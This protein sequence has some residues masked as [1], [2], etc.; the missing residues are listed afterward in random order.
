MTEQR[1]RRTDELITLRRTSLQVVLL[2]LTAVLYV[3]IV[4][5]FARHNHFSEWGWGPLLL[6]V[7]LLVAFLLRWRRPS[8]A[9]LAVTLGLASALFHNAWRGDTR[10][11]PHLLALTSILTGLF[12][13]PVT[14]LGVTGACSGLLIAVGR[15]AWGI[16]PFSPDLWSPILLIGAT[17]V[18]SV[19]TVG[20][21]SQALAWF[22]ERAAAAQANE[23]AAR[24]RQGQLARTLKALDEAYRRLEFANYDLARAR[25]VAE[26]ARV[27]KQEFA[28]RV[29][30]ELRTP[31]N[32]IV[33]L[34][35]IMYHSPERYYD[36]LPS[37]RFR[38]DTHELYRSSR[39]LLHL[40]DDVLDLTRV[41]VREMRMKL[42]PTDLKSVVVESIDMIRPL[43]A[44]DRVALGVDV[45]EHLP[46]VMIDR[47][48]VQQVLLNLLNNARRFTDEGRIWVRA[49]VDEDVVRVT[50]DD[51][52]IGIAPEEQPNVFKEFHQVESALARRHGGSGLGLAISRRFIDLHNGRIWVESSGVP[53]EGSRFH[54]T[55]PIAGTQLTPRGRLTSGRLPVGEPPQGRGRTLLLWDQ[56]QRVQE[57]LE[58]HLETYNVVP[59][60]DAET[61]AR[62]I[63]ERPVQA[64]VINP[65][66]GAQARAEVQALASR[67]GHDRL[68][69]LLCSLVGERELGQR[70]E[71][72]AYLVKPV[73][74]EALLTAV[75]RARENGRPPA[76][77]PRVLIVDN[78]VQMV[79]LL[80][81]MLQM[82]EVTETIDRA[83]GG[84]QGLEMMR[85]RRPDLVL[86][87]LMMPGVDG[88]RV[89]TEMR[90]DPELQDV[91]VIVITAQMHSLEHERQL[92]SDSLV[93]R[94]P[95][96]LTN[97]EV[98][99]Y[100]GALLQAIPVTAETPVGE[101]D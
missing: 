35:E 57:M 60:A 6:A 40:I 48:R 90:G 28:A 22:R 59:V 1:P 52:G 101:G 69:V 8:I 72:A 73:T 34:S 55:L 3:W 26:E 89:L 74:R 16:P 36:G 19:L 7:G 37:P 80:A 93:L 81:N 4:V 30:H 88:Y 64:L 33:A 12:F 42:E 95:R 58:R 23:E 11:A 79:R 56:E 78:D 39:H 50:V 68:P 29:S 92:G 32:V 46:L 87:D 91:P 100:L 43:V 44:E 77:G 62:L 15:H 18:L 51:T 67:F 65:A 5:L 31:L 96:G 70:L 86:L 61:A 85:A 47:A 76:Q 75:Q 45:P 49:Q 24:E 17:G 66:S 97:R 13:G 25:E 82:G 41:E 38:G 20:N 53:G 71:A 27:V 54:F 98:L 99:D 83:Y 63:E 94:V 84:A 9:A 14:V 10:L 21:L 2:S